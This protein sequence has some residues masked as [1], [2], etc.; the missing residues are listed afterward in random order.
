MTQREWGRGR[1]H[2]RRR[3]HQTRRRLHLTRRRL[4]LTRR[5]LHQTCCRLHQTRCRLLQTR[6]R[7]HQ[8]VTAR[9]G[10]RGGALEWR[11]S[12]SR[13]VTSRDSY[14][15][16]S[17]DRKKS[18]VSCACQRA[19]ARERVSERAPACVRVR[20][21]LEPRGGSLATQR[22][23]AR[24][25]GARRAI[26]VCCPCPSQLSES[27]IRGY[28]SRLSESAMRLSESAVVSCAVRPCAGLLR[29]AG[30]GQKPDR[31]VVKSPQVQLVRRRA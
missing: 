11:R 3:P 29:C 10:R 6:R 19:R 30:P 24:L 5:R 17:S 4:H 20:A 7:P 18:A 2:R 16:K 13:D 22:F 27:V 15:S 21:R 12:A 14:S 9:G 23:V 28:P 8:A 26:R 1:Q 31:K 25:R